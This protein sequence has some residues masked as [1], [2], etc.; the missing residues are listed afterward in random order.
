[1]GRSLEQKKFNL[2]ISQKCLLV[3]VL[4]LRPAH[5]T[6]LRPPDHRCSASAWWAGPGDPGD[7]GGPGRCLTSSAPPPPPAWPPGTCQAPGQSP[8]SPRS[9]SRP[10]WGCRCSAW[11]CRCCTCSAAPWW[12]TRRGD[13]TA[14]TSCCPGASWPRGI[15]CSRGWSWSEPAARTSH[16]TTRWR[17]SSWRWTCT[18]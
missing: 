3:A 10:S 9:C 15:S 4:T 8:L 11:P 13:C 12:S 7:P 14:G 18:L 6:L 2:L 16:S 17:R 1:M 5:S